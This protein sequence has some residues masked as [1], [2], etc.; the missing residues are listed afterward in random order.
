MERNALMKSEIPVSGVFSP[1]PNFILPKTEMTVRYLVDGA[2][3]FFDFTRIVLHV[4]FVVYCILR[5]IF[6]PDYLILVGILVAVNI[7]QLVFLILDYTNKSTLWDKT[8]FALPAVKQLVTL[9][10]F[11]F[12]CLDIFE[13]I[14][15]LT[16]WQFICMVFT[17]IGL[18]FALIGDL[19]VI[20]V[21]HFVDDILASFNSD[22][23][24]SGLVHRSFD[25]VKIAAKDAMKKPKVRNSVIAGG[26]GIA[27]L[28]VVNILRK[29]IRK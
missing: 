10:M 15:T 18:I 20:F 29:I 27:A 13:D 23:Q 11:V 12:F 16:V 3:K 24:V 8:K 22:I 4:V 1:E 7:A 2:V 6:K 9:T 17:I 26:I 28:S 5:F 21:P 25:E 19:F 14:N